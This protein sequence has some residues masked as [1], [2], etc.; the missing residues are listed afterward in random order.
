MLKFRWERLAR[1]L[2]LLA[3]CLLVLPLTAQTPQPVG[4]GVQ[5]HTFEPGLVGTPKIAW[6]CEADVTL[7]AWG[8]TASPGSDQDSSSVQ[9]RFF[10]GQTPTGP[11]FQV[12]Q[13][14][15]GSQ[16]GPIVQVLENGDFAIAW[17]SRPETGD[18][19]SLRLRTYDRVTLAPSAEREVI[20][21]LP[22]GNST[23]IVLT[24]DG[25]IGVAWF[26]SPDVVG[27]IYDLSGKPLGPEMRAEVMPETQGASLGVVTP[28]I[29]LLDGDVILQ[30]DADLQTVNGGDPDSEI[31]S[32]VRFQRFLQ[33]GSPAGPEV[34]VDFGVLGCQFDCGSTIIDP[35]SR[36]NRKGEFVVSYLEYERAF[37]NGYEWLWVK[38][39]AETGEENFSLRML[40]N[41]LRNED[42]EVETDGDF[43]VV[44]NGLGVNIDTDQ[45]EPNPIP[46][47]LVDQ[48]GSNVSIDAVHNGPGSAF[49]IAWSTNT[50][51]IWW[52]RFESF[53][54]IL[55]DGFE[56][57]D[58]SRW[59]VARGAE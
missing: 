55:Q 36:L 59:C 11:Q 57:G 44:W 26:E 34:L 35:Q 8:S 51:K 53:P 13:N 58:T 33:D 20:P 22:T 31:W 39:F 6:R 12:N 56:S 30:W 27:Q 40:G 50:Q 41:N 28:G 24:E 5:V 37:E 42:L 52:R 32:F 4:P 10:S 29:A 25:R 21:N 7:I 17:I 2:C 15:E 54:D 43:L 16:G 48:F 1:A 45:A 9:A 47:P 14:T 23:P 49:A 19:N 3:A 46:F 38:R 18:P